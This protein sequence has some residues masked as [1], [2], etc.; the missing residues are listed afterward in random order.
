MAA[1]DVPLHACVSGGGGGQ[2]QDDL[3][4]GGFQLLAHRADHGGEERVVGEH[5]RRRFGDDQRDGVGAPCHEAAGGGVGNVAEFLDG[6]HDRGSYVGL[7]VGGAV[8]DT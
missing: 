3:P 2:H 8:D 4:V 5:P 7:D 1:R 6:T